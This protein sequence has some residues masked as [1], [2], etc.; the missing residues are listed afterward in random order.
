MRPKPSA[1]SST[2][3]AIETLGAQ[4]QSI[5]LSCPSRPP[6]G[7]ESQWERGLEGR[8]WSQEELCPLGKGVASPGRTVR[9]RVCGRRKDALMSNFPEWVQA[10]LYKLIP[11]SSLLKWYCPLICLWLSLVSP[12][13]PEPPWRPVHIIP[14]LHPQ[15]PEISPSP[16]NL[17]GT[18]Q[19]PG[20]AA[21]HSGKFTLHKR[22]WLSVHGPG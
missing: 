5:H 1:V 12:N 19:P 15:Q 4:H 14:S 2:A 16:L 8:T 17:R 20:F 11:A 10:I 18:Q 21:T 6:L 13:P 9:G 7:N 22:K 3:A